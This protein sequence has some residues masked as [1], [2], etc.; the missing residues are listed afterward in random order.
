MVTSCRMLTLGTSGAPA[1]GAGVLPCRLWSLGWAG[2]IFHQLEVVSFPNTPWIQCFKV[3]QTPWLQGLFTDFKLGICLGDPC[4][5]A[6]LAEWQLL[7]Q[8][9]A[10]RTVQMRRWLWPRALKL[11]CAWRACLM[12]LRKLKMSRPLWSV[13]LPPC[14]TGGV[15]DLVLSHLSHLICYTLSVAL[16]SP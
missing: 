3:S 2:G 6:Y 16:P 5:L 15:L 8:G 4:D 11:C 1:T 10:A 14:S 7:F 9:N 12:Q 13:V